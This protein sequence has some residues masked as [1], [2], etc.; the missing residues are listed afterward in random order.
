M[1]TVRTQISRHDLPQTKQGRMGAHNRGV[2]AY[3]THTPALATGRP[4]RMAKSWRASY[5]T[6]R[7]H[8]RGYP[9]YGSKMVLLASGARVTRWGPSCSQG[10]ANTRL[11][12]S[13]P[14]GGRAAWNRTRPSR[15]R[16]AAAGR[17]L[18]P[19][20]R[21]ADISAS[22]TSVTVIVVPARGSARE[23]VWTARCG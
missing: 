16:R 15:G 19:R 21:Q 9:P 13:K 11:R 12:S 4:S 23:C 14:E 17:R 8:R 7:C 5:D 22:M 18:P 20:V 10:S 3:P 6:R 2:M 1:R